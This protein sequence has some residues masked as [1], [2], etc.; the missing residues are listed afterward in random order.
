L[1]EAG[2]SKV[3]VGAID[4]DVRV[5][6]SGMVRLRAAGIEV[7]GPVD[8]CVVEASD[9]GYFH[10][11]RTGRSRIVH[12]AALTLDGQIAAA[13]GTSQWI[14]S[15]AAREDAHELRAAMDAVMVGAGTLIAD[16]PRLDVRLEGYAGPQPRAVVVAGSRPLPAHARIWD[17]DPLVL[18]PGPIASLGEVVV[19]PGHAGAVD[20][21]A[22]LRATADRGL[23]D[24]MVEGGSVL[25]A[26]LW[27][28]GL[29]DAG[30]W[31]VAAMVGGGVGRAVFDRPFATLS[32]A[33]RVDIIDVTRLGT[34]LRIDWVPS[35]G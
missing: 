16:D 22:A 6:G 29:V 3:V 14:T 30:V 28:E 35:S 26:G 33:R 5:A 21:A 11:R 4:P 12:K 24:V 32:S 8:Q 19:V 10:H 9:P 27:E 25:A 18:A 20:L 31:Y 15:A 23:L 2:V 1:I 17:R 34:D 7:L 13:D